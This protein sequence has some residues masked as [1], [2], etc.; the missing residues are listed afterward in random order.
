MQAIGKIFSAITVGGFFIW[1]INY[2]ASPSPEK[3]TKAGELIAQAAIPW[4]LP[5]INFLAPLGII[6]FILIIV[7]LFYI[8]KNK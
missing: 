3:I 2:V 4:W 6:G 8:A 1:A 5:V 7:L